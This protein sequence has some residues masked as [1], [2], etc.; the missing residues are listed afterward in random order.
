MKRHLSLIA[1]AA[2]TV[3]G[4]GLYAG[5]QDTAEKAAKDAAREVDVKAAPKLN[6]GLPDGVQ[7]ATKDDTEDIRDPLAEGTEASFKVDGY[8]ELVRRFVDA[9]RNRIGEF[10]KGDNQQKLAKL[11]AIVGPISQQWEQKYG[12]KFD[13]NENLVFGEFKGFTIHQGEI[14]NPQLLSNWP[15]QQTIDAKAKLQGSPAGTGERKNDGKIDTPDVKVE[16]RDP[17]KND[18]K[19]DTPKVTVGELGKPSDKP[20]DRNLEKGRNVAVVY[21]PESHGKPE[22]YVSMIH[23]MPDAWKIDVPDTVD[24][25]KLHDN[26][27]N[28]LTM[29]AQHKDQWPTDVNEAYRMAAHCVMMAI[30]DLPHDMKK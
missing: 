12:K 21:F 5:A 2:M 15:V 30:Y 28:H 14:A 3:G 6:N 29:F 8:N 26:L 10:L 16:N 17:A 18:G 24:G 23:E 1:A 13:M 7:P 27:C 4:L 11:N 20:S 22:V 25:Q 9:D 19:I